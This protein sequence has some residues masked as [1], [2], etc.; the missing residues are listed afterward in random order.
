MIAYKNN[1]PKG[2]EVDIFKI[3]MIDL[4]F[5]MQKLKIAQYL[6]FSGS[7]LRLTGLVYFTDNAKISQSYV[8]K[9][10]NHFSK[11]VFKQKFVYY[12][13]NFS[14]MSFH[15]SL[16]KDTVSHTLRCLNN[17]IGLC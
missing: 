14:F 6:F 4:S 17:K 7:N 11:N 8:H 15:N 12:E 2:T 9:D 13:T 5:P 1:S 16:S 10:C 3:E